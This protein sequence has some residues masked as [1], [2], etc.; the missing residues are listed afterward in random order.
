M[1]ALLPNASER[2]SRFRTG[3]AGDAPMTPLNEKIRSDA[4]GPRKSAAFAAAAIKY[5]GDIR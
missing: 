5:R 3:G 4:F 1:S 2:M